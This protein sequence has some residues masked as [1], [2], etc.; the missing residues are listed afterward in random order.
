MQSSG[1]SDQQR[2]KFRP[3]RAF[4]GTRTKSALLP[5]S[6]WD[7]EHRS[8]CILYWLPGF[9]RCLK[10]GCW[11]RLGSARLTR[12][13]AVPVWARAWLFDI[14]FASLVLKV[15]NL[16]YLRCEDSQFF[17]RLPIKFRYITLGMCI[18]LVLNWRWKHLGNVQNSELLCHHASTSQ[19]L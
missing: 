15:C 4:C 11:A 9:V 7:Q 13:S 17:Y 6:C 1:P 18:I 2:L 19:D 16:K 12:F 3:G 10:G 8:Q 14:F 5:C